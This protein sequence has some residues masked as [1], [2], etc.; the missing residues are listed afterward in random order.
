MHKWLI[1]TYA[2]IPINYPLQSSRAQIL[3]KASDYIDFMKKKIQCHQTDIEML[4]KQNAVLETQC[5]YMPL[6]GPLVASL[7]IP[8]LRGGI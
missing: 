6:T 7:C 4:E 2:P 1:N 5:E 3:K 8:D